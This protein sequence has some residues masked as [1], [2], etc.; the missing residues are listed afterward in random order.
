MANT[1]QHWMKGRIAGQAKRGLARLRR[2]DVG[3]PPR[4]T[5]KAWRVPQSFLICQSPHIG[6]FGGTGGGSHRPVSVWA[7]RLGKTKTPGTTC[8]GEPHAIAGTA[9][10]GVAQD[11]AFLEAQSKPG[12]STIVATAWSGVVGAWSGIRRRRA[13]GAS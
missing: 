11:A 1:G 8:G 13:N 3:L 4:G 2:S 7:H 6:S 5:L 10:L 12:A 9:A